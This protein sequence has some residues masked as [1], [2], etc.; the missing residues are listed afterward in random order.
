MS[1][2]TARLL[3]QEE[4]EAH[5]EA[6]EGFHVPV[7]FHRTGEL[8]AKKINRCGMVAARYVLKQ[9]PEVTAH[10]IGELRE[11]LAAYEQAHHPAPAVAQEPPRKRVCWDRSE[12]GMCVPGEVDRFRCE[13]AISSN[14][15]CD[16]LWE[17][18]ATPREAPLA[19]WDASGRLEDM[20]RE[21]GKEE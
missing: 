10:G 17:G 5:D 3:T 1:D 12:T 11:A 9:L 2:P 20:P 19:D 4:V 8:S 16:L 21:A 6:G 15:H 18:F 14:G 13:R 7:I